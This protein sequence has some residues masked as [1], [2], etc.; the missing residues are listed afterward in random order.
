[1]RIHA[2]WEALVHMVLRALS[3]LRLLSRAPAP[4]CSVVPGGVCARTPPD[5]EVDAG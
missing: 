5:K 3:T 1:M 2:L 4:F